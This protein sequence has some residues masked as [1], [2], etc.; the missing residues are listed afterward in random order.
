MRS[1]SG[2]PKAEICFWFLWML[3]ICLGLFG[4]SDFV[5]H[6]SE[7]KWIINLYSIYWF[8][9]YIFEQ[10]KDQTNP[11]PFKT[12]YWVLIVS[13]LYG[14]YS[15]LTGIDL[16]KQT[17]QAH[18][19]RFGGP[20]DDPM[21]YAHIYAMYL[22]FFITIG[23]ALVLTLKSR[24]LKNVI[25]SF[26]LPVTA[27]SFT[28]LGVALSLTRGAWIGAFSSLFICMTI[29]KRRL[30]LGLLL[31]GL[32]FSVVLYHS[33]E[34]FKTRVDQALNP[35]D[36]HSYDSERYNLWRTNWAI[37]LDHPWLGIG[38]GEYK[39]Y[40]S[41]YF[42]TLGIP[43]DHFQSHA[44]N[45]YLHFL[46]NTG[47]LGTLFFM[48]FILYFLYVGLKG[49]LTYKDPYF[50]GCIASQLAF[51]VGSLTECNFERAKVRLVYLFF[52]SLTITLWN[53]HF[54]KHSKK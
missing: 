35:S 26:W 2:C 14:L 17:P 11:I 49:F 22:V 40:L 48:I 39:K 10:S 44:H 45:Q 32:L 4:S 42:E 53:Y 13:F 33:S 30:G 46:S 43:K 27:N 31:T 21:N 34:T 36:S 19:A 1:F 8:L 52:I 38:H 37:F 6:F 54:F 23:F 9:G 28:S 15:F 41:M 20:F 5:I 29:L 50:L 18:G 51:H 3:T 24:N 12:V 47:V 7:W 16:F 25:K